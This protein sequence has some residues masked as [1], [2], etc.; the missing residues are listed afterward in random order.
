[1][2]GIVASGIVAHATTVPIVIG[3]HRLSR[4]G[5]REA[6][7]LLAKL[8]TSRERLVM[9]SG[10]P[11]CPG[12]AKTGHLS[13]FRPYSNLYHVIDNGIDAGIDN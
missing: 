12:A 7:S 2:G 11:P 4:Q 5:A 8:K 1:M 10:Q 6:S 13:L 3:F 9:I